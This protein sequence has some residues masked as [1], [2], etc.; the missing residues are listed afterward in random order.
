M[1]FDRRQP[2]EIDAWIVDANG[3]QA[4]Y[5][6]SILPIDVDRSQPSTIG[7]IFGIEV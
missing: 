7:S 4:L 1:P 5:S 6:R 3:M 2:Y